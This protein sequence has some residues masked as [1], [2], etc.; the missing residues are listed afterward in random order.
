MPSNEREREIEGERAIERRESKREREKKREKG[1]REGGRTYLEDILDTIEVG[2]RG[3]VFVHLFG[4]PQKVLLF[5]APLPLLGG[6]FLRDVLRIRVRADEQLKQK[7]KQ[8][9]KKFSHQEG[10]KRGS[11]ASAGGGAAAWGRGE[12]LLQQEAE[13]G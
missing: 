4:S 8:S 5:G 9:L 3:G 11:A 10:E 1:E 7:A 12:Q 13:R 6:E 2:F